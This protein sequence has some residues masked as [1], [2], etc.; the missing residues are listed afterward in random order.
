MRR[1]AEETAKQLEIVKVN[2]QV[3]KHLIYRAYGLKC[4]IVA[5]P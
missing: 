1:R 4:M 5:H 3:S 2:R